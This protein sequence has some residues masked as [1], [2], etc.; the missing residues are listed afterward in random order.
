MTA[1]GEEITIQILYINHHVGST[2]RTINQHRNTMFMGHANDLLDGVHRAEDVA[3]MSQADEL[4]SFRHVSCD[5][6]AIY[7]TAV[8]GDGEVLDD[9]ATFHGLQLPGHDIGVVLHLGNQHLIA[10]LHLRLAERA[11]HEVDGLGGAACK[12][13]LLGLTRM[14]KLAHLLARRLMEVGGLLREVVHTTVH[15][16]IHVEILIAHSVEHAE[17]FLRGGRIIQIH[18][19]LTIHFASQNREILPYLIDIVHP[20]YSQFAAKVLLFRDLYKR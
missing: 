11:G 14:D 13:N 18:Q 3:D 6:I 10:C 19:R 12:D 7:E 1:E 20:C 5:F 9:D 8:V 17:R 4:R 2:L 16:R 15:I